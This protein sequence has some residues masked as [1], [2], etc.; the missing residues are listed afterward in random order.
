[1]NMINLNQ[2]YEMMKLRQFINKIEVTPDLKFSFH[3]ILVEPSDKLKA[4]MCDWD[5]TGLGTVCLAEMVIEE[6]ITD[7]LES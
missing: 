2:V 6:L 4:M 5:F 3:G 7:K 1:M